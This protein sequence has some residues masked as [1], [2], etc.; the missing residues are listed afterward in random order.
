VFSKTRCKAFVTGNRWDGNVPYDCDQ[1]WSWLLPCLFSCYMKYP[2]PELEH[3]LKTILR[4]LV[5]TK[6]SIVFAG[7]EFAEDTSTWTSQS[8]FLLT[9]RFLGI[10]RA[11]T[12][13]TLSTVEQ[14][15]AALEE[16]SRNAMCFRKLLMKIPNF[17]SK[18]PLTLSDY[19]CALLC[20]PILS[21]PCRIPNEFSWSF[22][23]SRST[24]WDS[25]EIGFVC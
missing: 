14:E 9:D 20:R 5:F 25:S 13:V 18:I 8:P 24:L 23:L 16:A 2:R 22:A 10:I 19:N 3:A 17:Y 6:I 21:L 15:H 4:Y 11:Y 7:T 1:T 12:C